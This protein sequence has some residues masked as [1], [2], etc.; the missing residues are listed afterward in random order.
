[1][2]GQ[3][4]TLYKT[5]SS[6]ISWDSSFSEEL[7]DDSNLDTIDNGSFI[8]AID[9]QGKDISKEMI[10]GKSISGMK[11]SYR[12]KGGEDGEEYDIRIVATGTT[13]GD[14]REHLIKLI[15]RDDIPGSI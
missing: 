10:F 3:T 5:I 14:V 1:M 15:V 12:I 8:T 4:I 11:F 9:S 2:P 6:S 13:T 7:P